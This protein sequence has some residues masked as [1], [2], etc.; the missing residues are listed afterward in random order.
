MRTQ[1]DIER[2]ALSAT[3]GRAI[4]SRETLIA[5]AGRGLRFVLRAR[6]ALIVIAVAVGVV[7]WGIAGSGV[8]GSGRILA[9]KGGVATTVSTTTSPT[10][11]PSTTSTTSTTAAARGTS[12]PSAPSQRPPTPTTPPA[13]P[14]TP[15]AASST[16]S[17]GLTIQAS[18]THL[19]LN[20]SSYRFLGVNAYE[21]A[22]A[23]GTNPGCG[24]MLSDA[25]LNQLFSSLAPN[26]LVRIW[27]FQGSMAINV[28]T[29][30]LDWGPLDRVFAAAAAHGQRLIAAVT[31]QGGT[32]DG[33]HWQ[34]PSWYQ[35]GFRNAFNDP[36]TTDGRGFTP[37][38]YWT[39]L[40]AIVS[41]YASSPA[42]GM[43]E[44]IS[45]AEASTCPPPD[46]PTNCSG[47]QT[48]PNEAAAA[49]AL[50]YFFD[51]VGGEIHALDP[52]HLVESGLL[53]G[54]QCGTQGSDFQYVSA[55][56]GID[57]LSY[58]DYYGASAEGG[59]QWNGL[60]VR[61]AQSAALGKPIIGGE[62]GTMAGTSAGC[63]SLTDRG[64]SF[65]AKEQAQLLAGSSGLLEWNWVPSV[66]APCSYDVGPGDPVLQ[67]TGAG[68]TAS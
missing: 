27:A 19:V 65:R 24:A 15:A 22:T 17:G 9:A 16:P 42:L 13:P 60:A 50:R 36:S 11:A 51:T 48:C 14:A 26:S 49:A 66:T 21:A 35:G 47:R 61:M 25:Q 28:H 68:V 18:G 67:S 2:R 54:G 31:D 8:A 40:Q 7:T 1:R 33:S 46:Q 10:P 62:V 52:H 39:Y 6:P 37:L 30:Q 45:E 41:R 20:G 43:W 23:W 32:C 56:P 4:P 64:G 12:T 29:G 57:V 38:S 55:S 58:H 59:D 53:G 34:D 5:N 44:P 63:L 3:Q